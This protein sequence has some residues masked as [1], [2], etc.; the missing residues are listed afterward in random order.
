VSKL[1]SS[2]TE[3]EIPPDP[4]ND[5]E[6][7]IPY[8]RVID[9][10]GYMKSGGANLSIIVA[11]P[12]QD[13][14]RSQN[15]LLDKIQGYLSHLYSDEFLRDAG[16][17]PNID[18]TKITVVLHPESS[19]GIRKLLNRCQDWVESKA[20]AIIGDD[21]QM[22]AGTKSIVEILILVI[23][24]L[25]NRLNLNSTNS[26]KQVFEALVVGGYKLF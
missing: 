22:S 14:E 5:P 26:S 7:P 15:R 21:K 13:D 23:T 16:C 4:E 17:E 3:H 9:V 19:P 11:S 18:N 12:L 8:L 10:A 24:L 6:H 20:Q 25:A 2:I 1:N